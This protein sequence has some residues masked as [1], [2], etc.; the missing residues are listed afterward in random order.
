VTTPASQ[1]RRAVKVDG[2]GLPFPISQG[3]TVVAAVWF[4]Q[5][6]PAMVGAV[7]VRHPDGSTHCF[8]G[9]GLPVV[10]EAEANDTDDAQAIA[11]WGTQID[12]HIACAILGPVIQDGSFVAP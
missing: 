7:A 1:K 6:T 12:Y 4:P 11:D 3:R 9:T 10:G 8:L 5:D 2:Q